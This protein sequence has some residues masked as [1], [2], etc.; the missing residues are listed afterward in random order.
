MTLDTLEG[1]QKSQKSPSFHNLS[2]YYYISVQ[3]FKNRTELNIQYC[4]IPCSDDIIFEFNRELVYEVLED[5]VCAPET[6]LFLC[7]PIS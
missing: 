6:M 2:I 5:F 1:E 3:C 7:K 4:P